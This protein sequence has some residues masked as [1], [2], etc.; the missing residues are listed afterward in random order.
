MN[1]NRN[2]RIKFLTTL[3]IIIC[4][5]L[6]FKAFADFIVVTTKDNKVSKVNIYDIEKI[7]IE[8]STSYIKPFSK[9]AKNNI[10]LFPNPCHDNLNIQTLENETMLS[11]KI[12][13]ILGDMIFEFKRDDLPATNRYVWDLTGNNGARVQ[14]GL[15]FIQ[16][17]TIHNTYYD[18]IIMQ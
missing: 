3:S 13:N 5:S 15:Y 11:L 18:K 2:N 1:T 8:K 4:L 10:Q 16:L 9:S 17:T 14:A 7:L 6:P 12:F